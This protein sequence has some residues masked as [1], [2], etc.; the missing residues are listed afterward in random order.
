M[1]IDIVG[2]VLFLWPGKAR[3]IWRP[4][5]NSAGQ[6]GRELFKIGK[7]GNVPEKSQDEWGP[8]M[9]AFRTESWEMK[10]SNQHINLTF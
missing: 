4:E 8:Y 7:T 10:K 5:P 1:F 2:N 3:N 9:K 6:R